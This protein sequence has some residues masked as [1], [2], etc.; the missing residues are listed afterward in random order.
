VIWPFQLGIAAIPIGGVNSSPVVQYL[1]GPLHVWPPFSCSGLPLPPRPL[2]FTNRLRARPFSQN[3]LKFRQRVAGPSS[4]LSRHASIQTS[5][6]PPSQLLS[7]WVR[8]WCRGP[9]ILEPRVRP[10]WVMQLKGACSRSAPSF[11]I[12]NE[13]RKKPVRPLEN[14]FH[15]PNR[16]NHRACDWHPIR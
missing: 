2:L 15:N 8:S 3:C 9:V 12:A 5:W 14:A 6:W 4:E 16:L 10:R 11:K 13:Q 7:S 1:C